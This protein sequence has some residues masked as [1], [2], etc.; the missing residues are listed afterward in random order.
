MDIYVLL[1]T[2]YKAENN[3]RKLK[4][5]VRFDLSKRR[6]LKCRFSSELKKRVK[7]V[8]VSLLDHMQ[9]VKQS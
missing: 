3:N 4:N 2:Y 7:I 5:N 8:R 6:L 9:I 1:K